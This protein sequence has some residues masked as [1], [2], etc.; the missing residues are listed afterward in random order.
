MSALSVIGIGSPFGNDRLGWEVI[1]CLKQKKQLKY[2][3]NE[4]L[5][6]ISLDRPGLN[7][8]NF[9]QNTQT[10]FLIDA[11]KTGASLGTLHQYEKKE[12]DPQFVADFSHDIGLGYTLK[13][14]KTLNLL[15]NN[16]RL[17]GIEINEVGFEST[18]SEIIK[19]SI[20][21]LANIIEDDIINYFSQP[22]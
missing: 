7:L 16:I 17:Y 15:P 9:L 3:T 12:I 19:K 13:M 18:P 10:A 21:K 14:G 1:D 22:I 11:L 5:D 20:L 4:Q 2:L 6:L 8:L